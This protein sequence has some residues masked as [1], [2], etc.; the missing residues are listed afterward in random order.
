[1]ANASAE[2][3]EKRKKKRETVASSRGPIFV[4]ILAGDEAKQGASV[5]SGSLGAVDAAICA[6]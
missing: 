3:N 1:M 4:D 5:Y 2:L 6:W